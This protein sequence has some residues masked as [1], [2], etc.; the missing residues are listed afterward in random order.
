[1]EV[2]GVS[3]GGPDTGGQAATHL[4]GTRNIRVM[5]NLEFRPTTTTGADFALPYIQTLA[6]INNRQLTLTPWAGQNL[7]HPLLLHGQADTRFNI[8][9]SGT[10]S[11][12]TIHFFTGEKPERLLWG[13][14]SPRN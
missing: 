4:M 5:Q 12:S 6:S 9:V 7:G 10:G 8:M 1:M 2:G 11:R 13:L 14:H 3:L